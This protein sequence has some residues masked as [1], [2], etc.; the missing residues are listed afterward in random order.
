MARG[1]V[2]LG[3]AL[4]AC[5]S[6]YAADYPERPVRIIVPFPA[7]SGTDMLARFIGTKLV[8]RLGKPVVVDNRPG[9]NGIIATDLTAHAAPD[10][11]T[12]QFMS[13]SHTMNAAVYSKLPFD[14]VK[15]FTPIMRLASGPL[16]LVANPAF[17]ASGVKGLIDLARAKPDTIS[18]A[19]SGT[20]GINHFA[21]ALFSR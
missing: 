10:G 9:A 15:S 21:G 5:S 4:V 7:G 13:V 14:P 3:A 16:V 2:C 11:Y 1:I 19:V 12:L 18:Y 17:P 8:D 6:A 20:G